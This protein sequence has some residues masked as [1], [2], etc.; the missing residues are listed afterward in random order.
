MIQL[1]F[2]QNI[3][4]SQRSGS[5]VLGKAE[6]ALQLRSRRHVL[7]FISKIAGLSMVQ[8]R[9]SGDDFCGVEEIE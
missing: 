6:E 2:T 3:P 4:V 1:I 7:V 5:S 9:V 8:D